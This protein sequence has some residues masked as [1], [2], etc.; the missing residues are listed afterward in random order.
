MIC[1]DGADIGWMQVS[2]S[3]EELNLEQLHLLEAYRRRGIGT[4]LVRDLQA[5]CREAGRPFR[6]NVMR[7]NSA[8]EFYRRLG[9]SV[10]G[11][12]K[13]KFQMRWDSAG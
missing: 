6:L 3:D 7:G 13:E 1:I 2:D 4:R 10:V 5:R 9:F 11:E 12:D 8:I